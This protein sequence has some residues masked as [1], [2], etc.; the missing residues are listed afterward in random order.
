MKYIITLFILSLS[1]VQLALA[2]CT[3]GANFADSTFG[4]WPDTT[5]NFPVANVNVN[6]T[7]DLN[8]KVPTDAGDVNI[9]FAGNTINSFT[10]DSVVGLPPGMDYTCNVSSC[11]YA[12]GEN[13]C[14]QINGTCTQVGVYEISIHV[15]A[16]LS[17]FGTNVPV[18]YEFSGYR[19][20]V[21]GTNSIDELTTQVVVYPNPNSGMFNVKVGNE[22]TE[23]LVTDLA[24]KTVYS[25]NLEATQVATN[26]PKGI[27]ILQLKGNGEQIQQ[28]MVIE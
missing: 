27:Y 25:Q 15:T 3:P 17:I 7:T 18:P 20:E 24:G 1:M 23:I 2:Q 11:F 13:G 21:L 12:G 6:Y 9:L 14:A 19:I 26:L 10:V 22:F 16:S 28:R 8:F 5:T 4:A